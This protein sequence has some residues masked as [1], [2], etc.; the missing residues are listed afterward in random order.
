MTGVAKE[1]DYQ[2]SALTTAMAAAMT[3]CPQRTEQAYMLC[4]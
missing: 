2:A 4:V 3:G 1:H